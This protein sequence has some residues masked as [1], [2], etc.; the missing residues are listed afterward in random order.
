MA[1]PRT[2]AVVGS[3]CAGLAA[4]HTL[5]SRG[6]RVTLFEAASSIGGHADTRQVEGVDVD[7]GF[8]VFNRVTYPNMAR[9]ARGRPNPKSAIGSLPVPCAPRS[10][11]MRSPSGRAGA[12]RL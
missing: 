12:A 11:V 8:M 7:V 5:A 6:V 2:A 4:A 3:G 1:P 9:A 10:V